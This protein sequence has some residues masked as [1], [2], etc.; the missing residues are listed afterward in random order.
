VFFICLIAFAFFLSSASSA[1]L[2]LSNNDSSLV[3]SLFL[4]SSLTSARSVSICASILSIG[5]PSLIPKSERNCLIEIGHPQPPT[6]I[7]TDNTTARGIITGTIKQKRSKAIDMGFYWLKDRFEQEQFDYVW[8]PGIENLA[9]YPTKHHSGKHHSTVR[10]IY[11][12]MKNKSPK[13]I[14]GCV[15]LLA[16]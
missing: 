11:I 15:E 4:W 13:T 10:P 7:K 8:G 16:R 2:A 1:I 3:V 6:P 14:Q 5:I 9:D 12:Y